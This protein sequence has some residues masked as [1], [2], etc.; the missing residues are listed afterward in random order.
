MCVDA[1]DP[2]CGNGDRAWGAFKRSVAGFIDNAIALADRAVR[3]LPGIIAREAA[4]EALTA[5]LPAVGGLVKGRRVAAVAQSVGRFLTESAH[6]RR[7]DTGDAIRDAAHDFSRIGAS[8]DE[9]VDAIKGSTDW[10]SVDRLTDGTLKLGK[11]ELRYT[12]QP[13]STGE[14]VV[15][16]WIKHAGQ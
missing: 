3:A 13:L 11:H 7:I 5:A 10:Q 6:L 2:R 8:A 14:V 1:R 16:A 15:N 4:E 12:L 9:V